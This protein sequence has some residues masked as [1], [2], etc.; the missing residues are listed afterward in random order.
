MREITQPL[1]KLYSISQISYDTQVDDIPTQPRPCIGDNRPW[2]IPFLLFQHIPMF[3]GEFKPSRKPRHIV[4]RYQAPYRHHPISNFTLNGFHHT[5]R[6]LGTCIIGFKD[7][8]ITNMLRKFGI[9]AAMR[10][11]N[12][13]HI[14]IQISGLFQFIPTPFSSLSTCNLIFISCQSIH[15]TNGLTLL[16]WRSW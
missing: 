9:G 16:F 3:I 13:S 8:M 6:K 10:V 1:Q 5:A 2:D 12:A 4:N 14:Q 11:P 7:R 15:R